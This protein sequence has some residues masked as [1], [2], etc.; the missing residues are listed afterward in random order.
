MPVEILVASEETKGFF[1][2]LPMPKGING[3]E[4]KGLQ[5]F[6]ICTDASKTFDDL[7]T[8]TETFRRMQDFH[9]TMNSGRFFLV[10]AQRNSYPEVYSENP[11]S[12]ANDWIKSLY[13][14]SAIHSYSAAYD[15]Y[16][17]ILWICFELY[18]QSTKKLPSSISNDNFLKI[19]Q[20]CNINEIKTQSKVLGDQLCDNLNTF[21]ELK[22]TKDVR[23]LCKQ[24][25][26]RQSISYSELSENKHPFMIKSSNYN[27]LKTLSMYS[28]DEVIAMLKQFHKDLTDL[29]D[30]SIPIVKKHLDSI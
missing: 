19:L 13:L 12:W 1:K 6:E 15:I 11:P 10:N 17:Q 18:K 4:V 20:G 14:N 27:S 26:H 9:D 24:I 28:I 2:E 5:Y 29:S 25:K 21:V 16:L 23:N 30:F 8:V 22:N 7:A 3:N